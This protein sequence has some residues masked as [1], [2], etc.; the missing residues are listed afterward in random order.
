M[1]KGL[2]NMYG[3]CMELVALEESVYVCCGGAQGSWLLSSNVF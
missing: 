1:L 2:V 3:L